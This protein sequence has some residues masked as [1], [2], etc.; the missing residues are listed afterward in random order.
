[1]FFEIFLCLKIFCGK[2]V[3]IYFL[4]TN[5]LEICLGKFLLKFFLAQLL[6]L[7]IFSGNIFEIFLNNFYK[8]FWKFF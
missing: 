4:R 3:F 7:E 6:N 5:F 2:L 1:M 8:V